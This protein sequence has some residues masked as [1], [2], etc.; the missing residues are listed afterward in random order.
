MPWLHATWL[1][2][3]VFLSCAALYQ[4]A[5][6]FF[7]LLVTVPARLGK[8]SDVSRASSASWFGPLALSLFFW[9]LV[10]PCAVVRLPSWLHCPPAKVKIIFRC[11]GC[12]SFIFSPSGRSPF[13]WLRSSNCGCGGGLSALGCVGTLRCTF[14]F[15]PGCAKAEIERL[16]SAQD[17]PST[18]PHRE[19]KRAQAPAHFGNRAIVFRSHFVFERMTHAPKRGSMH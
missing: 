13:C 4:F 2:K 5:P 9:L 17:R 11:P 18:V 1:C 7:L 15:W 12:K 19:G 16:Y 6:L 14:P 8:G 3:A 10:L